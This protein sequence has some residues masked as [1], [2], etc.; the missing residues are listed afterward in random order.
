MQI[1]LAGAITGGEA[2]L[3]AVGLGAVDLQQFFFQPGNVQRVAGFF[4]DALGDHFG[5]EVLVA[6]HFHI[7]DHAFQHFH[8][9]GAAFQILGR[10]KGQRGQVAAHAVHFVN[11]VHQLGQIGGGQRMTFVRGHHPAHFLIRDNAV[12]FHVNALHVE[13][14]LCHLHDGRLGRHLQCGRFMLCGKRIGAG[15]ARRLKGIGSIGHQHAGVALSVDGLGQCSAGQ[16]QGQSGHQAGQGCKLAIGVGNHGRGVLV[17]KGG[18][19]QKV[20]RHWI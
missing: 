20:C 4:R 3:Q 13:H 11:L 16:G 2:G 17:R 19:K 5:L 12:A 6:A 8:G 10:H 14:I 15:V 9:D 1:G 18:K 7:T